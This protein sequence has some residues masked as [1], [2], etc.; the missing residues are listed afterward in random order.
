MTLEACESRGLDR[1]SKLCAMLGI[2]IRRLTLDAYHLNNN[3]LQLSDIREACPNVDV[4]LTCSAC[5]VPSAMKALRESLFELRTPRTIDSKYATIRP[6]WTEL[7]NV[8]YCTRLRSID[9]TL[10]DS[11]A[12]EYL[13]W[14]LSQVG[15]QLEQLILNMS[16]ENLTSGAVSSIVSSLAYYT[17]SL[18]FISLR[19]LPEL[20]SL[21]SIAIENTRLN[22]VHLQGHTDGHNPTFDTWLV[23]LFD[24]FLSNCPELVDI[25]FDHQEWESYHRI[26]ELDS[27]CASLDARQKVG[28]RVNND[29]YEITTCIRDEFTVALVQ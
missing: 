8:T 16:E 24:D 3:L 29:F 23:A 5:S 26:A 4:R 17:G 11:C 18:R 10:S 7:E 27:L 22:Y 13:K 28:V 12:E 6:D 1:V 20:T 25:S 21:C 14:I 19:G 2:R 9:V 15:I